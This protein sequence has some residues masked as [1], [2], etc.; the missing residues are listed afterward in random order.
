[1]N[2]SFTTVHSN[3]IKKALS[4]CCTLL[5]AL[6]L[7]TPGWSAVTI[8]PTAATETPALSQTALP[9]AHR[10]VVQQF[11]KQ[12]Q[13]K[14]GLDHAALFGL[15]SGFKTNTKVLALMSKQ[16]EALPWYQYHDRILTQKRIQEG[17]LFWKQH[18]GTLAKIQKRFGVPP[19]III[20]ILGIE[21]SY[22]QITGSYPLVESL[23]TLA[24]D[25]PRRSAFFKKEL[26]ILLLLGQEGALNLRT[27]QGSYAGA[28]GM[29]QFMPSSYQK[30]AIDCSG[31][32]QR[33]LMHN[34][35]DVLGSVANYLSAHGWKPGKNVLFKTSAP[36][37]QALE[38]LGLH[39]SEDI[40]I[41]NLRSRGLAALALR[42][43]NTG[44]KKIKIIA[45]QKNVQDYEYH[46]GLS[47]FYTLMRYNNSVHYAMAVYQLSQ[48]LRTQHAHPKHP[49]KRGLS[50]KT[51]AQ[52]MPS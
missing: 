45:L 4:L 48:A 1:M 25:Y 12:M 10:K 2:R 31:K 37:R 9:F 41:Q 17:L 50:K 15:F 21:S 43:H 32:G 46:V 38:S 22:G 14:H 29:P 52:R 16:Y 39:R 47:N 6:L 30:Y 19:E 27:A 40:A 24:F 44:L 23:A 11:I 36:T 20:S 18:Q 51:S 3:P 49:T 13:Q 26:E 7:A 5:C 35:E 42:L 8:P 28:M 34:V 33:D